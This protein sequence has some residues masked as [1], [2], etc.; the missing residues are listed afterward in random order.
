MPTQRHLSLTRGRRQE[1]DGSYGALRNDTYA[2]LTYGDFTWPNMADTNTT[3]TYDDQNRVTAAYGQRFGWQPW[4]SLA[5]LGGAV[6]G[7]TAEHPHAV[8]LVNGVDRYDYD[9][10]GSMVVRSK[11]VSGQE[12]RW[13]ANNRLAQVVSSSGV[14]E[15]YLYDESGQRIRQVASIKSLRKAPVP[16][17]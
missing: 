2:N 5:S 13:D 12:L 16:G 4:G 10:N 9:A 6:Y 3:F 7:Y 17:K 11:G 1:Y 14:T 15:T 8:D